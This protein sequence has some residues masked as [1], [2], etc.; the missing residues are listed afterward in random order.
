MPVKRQSHFLPY[1]SVT[2]IFRS[3]PQWRRVGGGLLLLWMWDASGLDLT[4]AHWFGGPDGFPLQH[5]PL[6]ADWL[7]DRVRQAGWWLL[8]GLTVAVWWPVGTLKALQRR[9]RAWMMAAVWLSLLLVVTVKGLSRTSCPWEL[10]EFGGAVPYI[11]H[12][13]WWA[14]DGGSGRCFPAGHA[15]TAFAFLA[16]AVWWQTVSSKTGRALWFTVVSVGLVLGWAQQARGAH[17]F[18]HTLWT[19]WLCW[20]TAVT[21]HAVSR[22]VAAPATSPRS[23]H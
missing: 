18:S 14:R 17:Y 23:R 15:S 21:L 20:A 6:L 9:E 5:H 4:L 22:R 3:H 7:H 8:A 12:W 11:S 16:V 10:A 19:A 13:D 1:F 2:D